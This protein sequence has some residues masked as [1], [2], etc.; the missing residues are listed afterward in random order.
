[1]KNNSD[2]ELT[3]ELARRLRQKD[4]AY[5]ALMTLTK[6]LE[7]LNGRLA[8]SEK[9]KSHFLSNIR[10]EINNPLTSVLTMCDF[11]IS[12]PGLDQETL[13]SAVCTIHKEAFSLNFQLRNIFAAAEL[14]AGE[15]AVNISKTEIPSLIRGIAEAFRHKALEKMVQISIDIQERNGRFVFRADP[16][17][18]EW[19]VS[20]LLSNAIEYSPAGQVVEI[21][22]WQDENALHVSVAD[23]GAGIDPEDQEAIFERFRQLDAGLAK[24]HGGHGLGLSI[25][26]AALELLSGRITVSGKK[27]E[28]AVFTV[29]VPEANAR[30][31][32]GEVLSV[33]GN[34]FFFDENGA[35]ERF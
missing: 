6:K 9:V 1:M 29:S 16:E 20:N 5:S 27:G 17:K 3:E 14:E 23:R 12:N 11:L 19:I 30:D 18:L 31:A 7:V 2:R 35:G 32:G 13:K 8:E 25:T 24:R 33:D 34:N 28:G 4:E 22:A 26:K 10:N 15:S 21:K